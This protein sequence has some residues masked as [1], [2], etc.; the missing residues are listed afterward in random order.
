M[1]L[2][3]VSSALALLMA[4][5][6]A[7]DADDAAALDDAAVVAHSFD[8]CSDFHGGLSSVAGVVVGN[9]L[10]K[11]FSQEGVSAAPVAVSGTGV[12]EQNES[13]RKYNAK[14]PKI[15]QTP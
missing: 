7:D 13:E 10:G 1:L 12:P 5:V 8:G 9:G 14:M 3:S 15:N 11:P 2:G 6:F 4:L